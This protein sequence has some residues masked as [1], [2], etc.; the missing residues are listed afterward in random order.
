[1]IRWHFRKELHS[2]QGP[3]QLDVQA[4]AATG[5]ITGLFGPSG[6]GKTSILRMIAGLMDPDEGYL[7]VDDAVWFDSKTQQQ[8]LPQ[9]RSVGF[10]FQDYALFPHLRVRE[11]LH[12]ALPKGD[13][14]QIVHELMQM[15]D[16]HSLADRYPRQLSGGQQQRVA[17]ARAIVRKPRILLLDEPLAALDSSMRQTLQDFLI[18]LKDT[19]TL[20][21]ILVSH[22]LPELFKLAQQVCVVEQGQISRHGTPAEL[23][24]A[25][26]VSGR[27]RAQ[28]TIVQIRANG[29]L[30]LVDVL[31]GSEVVNVLASRED[32]VGLQVGSP[33]LI[34][35][36]AFNPFIVGMN[37]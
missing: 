14:P 35:S 9:D 17:L 20:T 8:R 36:K 34:I 1:M 3:M 24:A 7:Q 25:E 16:L 21:I 33:V 18:R 37:V 12:F 11:N 28:G 26:A 10:V 32:L 4:M 15:M 27:Y 22:D 13:S 29:V 23:F 19:Y 6:S 31:V 2:A 30:F 5:T